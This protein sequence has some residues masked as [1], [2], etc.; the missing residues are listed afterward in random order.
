MTDRR[1]STYGRSVAAAP[2]PW[3]IVGPRHA[4]PQAGAARASGP[5]EDGGFD[6]AQAQPPGSWQV[7]AKEQAL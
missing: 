2:G 6:T 4:R 5:A 3:Q 1:A 7:G